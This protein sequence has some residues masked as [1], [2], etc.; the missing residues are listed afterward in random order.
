MDDEL[1]VVD[2]SAVR[3]FGGDASMDRRLTRLRRGHYALAA[4][5]EHA[6]VEQRY[7]ARVVAA[8]RA[9][10][11]MIFA[12]ES[13]LLL[14]GLPIDGAPTYVFGTGDPSASGARGDIRCSHLPIPDEHV[15]IVQDMR[16]SS[17]AWTLAD[18]AR[19]RIPGPA[20]AAIDGALRAGIVTRAEVSAAISAQSTQHRVRARWSLA[21]ADA[22]AES[23]GE[24]RSRVA[25]AILGFPPPRLQVEVATRLGRFRADFGWEIDG[26]L[27]LG[28]FDGAVKYGAIAQAAGRSGVEVLLE[29]KRREDALR[30]VAEIRRWTWADLIDPTRLERILASAGLPQR[31][32]VLPA[33]VRLLR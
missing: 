28:E 18:V 22:L 3:A 30:E 6:S 27:L 12:L 31:H 24:S 9:R 1:E 2:A 19:R 13:A 4:E 17:V 21:F 25:I 16:C 26:R 5:I 15:V 32:R 29:E 11:G 7:R 8:S 14:H 23:V 20:V 33:G 10:P